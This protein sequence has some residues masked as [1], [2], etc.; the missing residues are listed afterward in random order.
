MS[1]AASTPGLVGTRLGLALL[2]AGLIVASWLRISRPVVV[3]ASEAVTSQISVG[4]RIDL[5]AASVVELTLLPGIGPTLAERI[6]EDR[7]A[8]GPFASAG[9]LSRVSGIGPATI[10]RARPY[11][12]EEPP[13]PGSERQ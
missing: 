10:E 9:D 2:V 8:R 7:T 11:L 5:N 13:K 6:V 3:G 4:M 12:V 1:G